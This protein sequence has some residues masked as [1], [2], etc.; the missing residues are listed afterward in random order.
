MSVL[1]VRAVKMIET[2]YEVL[3]VAFLLGNK[4]ILSVQVRIVLAYFFF[5]CSEMPID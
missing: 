5:V 3:I 2:I 4:G 1:E